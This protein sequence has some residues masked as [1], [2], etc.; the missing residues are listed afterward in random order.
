MKFKDK[1]GLARLKFPNGNLGGFTLIE[2]LVVIAIIGILS[3]LAVVSLGNARVRAR[4]SKRAADMRAVQSALEIFYTDRGTY[5][6]LASPGAN[7]EDQYL[8]NTAGV[9]AFS[10]TACGT[11]ADQLI[12]VPRDPSSN[13]ANSDSA[14]YTYVSASASNTY[15]ISVTLEGATGTLPAGLNCV[16]PGG[17]AGE[18][19]DVDAVCP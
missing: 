6:V 9:T 8:C 18:S 1:K 12:R 16:S 5:P 3:T 7:I 4:D 2:L 19:A 10:A 11:A 14:V 17:I 13:A 15:M